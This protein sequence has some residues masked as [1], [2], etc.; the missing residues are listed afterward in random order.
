[1]GADAPILRQ[2]TSSVGAFREFAA[3]QLVLNQGVANRQVGLGN[4]KVKLGRHPRLI[5][6][7]GF[8]LARDSRWSEQ[9]RPYFEWHAN[10]ATG[11]IATGASA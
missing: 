4:P 9:T 6:L 3:T 1:V 10:W 5:G 2:P 7:I 8:V 11:A